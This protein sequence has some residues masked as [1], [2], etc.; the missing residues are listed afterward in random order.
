MKRQCWALSGRAILQEWGTYKG[1]TGEE[2]QRKTCPAHRLQRAAGGLG[3]KCSSAFLLSLLR[4]FGSDT[5]SSFSSISA[6]FTPVTLTHWSCV[7]HTCTPKVLLAPWGF[8]STLLRSQSCACVLHLDGPH[9]L[10]SASPC[11]AL[12]KPNTFLVLSS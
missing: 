3:F 10:T 7:G 9:I 12:S 8:P 1:T 6:R 11:P 5:Q 4:D 2:C